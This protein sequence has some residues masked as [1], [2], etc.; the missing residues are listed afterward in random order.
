M[1]KSRIF[2]IFCPNLFHL[3]PAGCLIELRGN[4]GEHEPMAGEDFLP[5]VEAEG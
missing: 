3:R 1:C 5:M 2:A 4:L